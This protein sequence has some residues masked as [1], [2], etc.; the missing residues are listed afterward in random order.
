MISKKIFGIWLECWSEQ[1][2]IGDNDAVF[3]RETRDKYRK[4]FNNKEFRMR[5]Y[6]PD[7]FYQVTKDTVK[8]I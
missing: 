6:Y 7:E 1:K 4:K 5:L 2:I 3:F 8:H